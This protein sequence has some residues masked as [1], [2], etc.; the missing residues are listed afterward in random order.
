MNRDELTLLYSLIVVFSAINLISVITFDWR[1][2]RVNT[3]IC[4]Y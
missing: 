2:A 3:A 4:E 1:K